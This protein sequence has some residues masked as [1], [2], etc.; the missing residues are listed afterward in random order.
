MV[1]PMPVLLVLTAVIAIA[2]AA[3]GQGRRSMRFQA[4]GRTEALRWQSSVRSKLYELMM[5]GGRPQRVPLKPEIVRRIEVPNAP[6]VLEELTI[7]SLP[8]RRAH[9][10][11]AVPR[12]N[13]RGPAV[14]AIHGHGGTGEQIVRGEGLYWYGRA[15]A[16]MGYVVIAPDVGQHTL[17]HPN[18]SLMGER[19]W[20]CIRA[21][22]YACTRPEVDPRRLGVCG[23]SL[24]GETTMYVAALDERLKVVDS[25][26]W[27]TTVDNM[28]NG[29]CT[30]Y[31]FPGLAEHF[32]FADIFGCLAPRPL[33]ME[34]GE[35]ERAPGGFPLSIARGAYEEIKAVYR[36][37]GATEKVVLTA[38]PGGHV[39]VGYDFWEP[40][41]AALGAPDPWRSLS[42]P[43]R[44]CDRRGAIAARCVG[45]SIGVLQGWWSARD[46]RFGLLPRTLKENV[47]APNDNAADLMPFLFITDHLA[48]AGYRD[49]LLELL[50]SEVRLTN[51]DGVL[52][53]WFSMETG[54]W[55]HPAADLNRLIFGAAEYCKD[56]LMPMTE[57]MGKGP[58]TDRM[59]QLLDTIIER[60]PVKTAFGTIPASDTEVNGDMLQVLGR[61]YSITRKAHYLE[62][63]TRIA[64][65]YCL[66]VI[67]SSGGIPAH[68]WDFTAHRA[69]ADTFN[70][71]DHGNEIV[72]G[73]A[74]AYICARS[75]SPSAA[76]RWRE[77]IALML[78]RLLAACRGPEGLWVNQVTASS[79]QVRDPQPPDTW[80]YTLAGMLAFADA[81]GDVSLRE[82]AEA[83]IQA[84]R[85]P[86]YTH[87]VGADA[88]ADSIE[89]AILLRRR[90]RS[91]AIDGWLNTVLPIFLAWQRDDGIVEGW[92]G[93]G[94]YARTAM[95][96]ALYM[97]QGAS[98]RPWVQGLR[99]GAVP[100]G[101]SLRLTLSTDVS[102][103]GRFVFDTQRH[104]SVLALATDY[105]RLN[106][107]P[108]WFTVEPARRYRVMGLPG[109]PR[110][111]SGSQM[112]EGIALQL[113]AGTHLVLSV[114][115]E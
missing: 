111:F 22:D 14:L 106:S 44:E 27:L 56:G 75:Y 99:L 88:Y 4:T 15:L 39:L 85:H 46:P 35:R 63:L 91:P 36:L 96:V 113:P 67:P 11:M 68:R 45:R 71:N 31:D 25:S 10:W 3:E 69:V 5:G 57:I 114:A 100:S 110:T 101:R 16:E 94:N 48:Q 70:L 43:I 84:L 20:D 17:Q 97:T 93:D 86:R 53:D 38:H 102:W 58:W 60:A 49:R 30:C 66:E 18:W 52:P 26:G 78:R 29:H 64:D 81:S 55:V 8:D 104:R 24:G 72:L 9:L 65:A 62:M 76:D 79:G 82:S 115:P 32:D 23:L 92:Y 37:F 98:C 7:Q 59:L 103:D 33:V 90:V 73:L 34:I 21:L 28:R 19:T 80:G 83:M 108:E 40:L 51:R 2:P 77:P 12:S 54:T 47:W 95:M 74:E 107:W 89:G 41:R 1:Y 112:V 13:R 109:G 105:P 50:T 6:Y 61:A 87:W 42:D